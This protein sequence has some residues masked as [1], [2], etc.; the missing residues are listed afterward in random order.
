MVSRFVRERDVVRSISNPNVVRVHDLV[1][2]GDRLGIVM[3]L[4]AAGHLRRNLPPPLPPRSNPPGCWPRWPPGWPPC[5]P[6]AWC[7]AI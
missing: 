7:T 4:F 6:T 1:V 3:D 2:E 5:T